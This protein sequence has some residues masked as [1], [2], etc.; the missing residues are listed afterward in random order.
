MLTEQQVKEYVSKAGMVCPYCRST[1]IEGNEIDMQG[2][3][4][5]QGC[6]CLRCHKEWTDEYTLTGIVEDE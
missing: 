6:Y 2:K 3:Y 5:Y 1:Q 4:V